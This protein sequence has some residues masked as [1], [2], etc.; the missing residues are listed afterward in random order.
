VT[1]RGL[2]FMSLS[3]QRANRSRAFW[4]EYDRGARFLPGP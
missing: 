4:R 2:M 3:L 1:M